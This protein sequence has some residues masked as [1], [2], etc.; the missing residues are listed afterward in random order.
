MTMAARDFVSHRIR[1]L[2]FPEAGEYSVT[3]R[4]FSHG[5]RHKLKSGT[6]QDFDARGQHMKRMTKI[7]IAIACAFG[8]S[9]ALAQTVQR[10]DVTVSGANA[11]QTVAQASTAVPIQTAQTGAAAGGAAGGASAGGF[12]AGIGVPGTVGSTVV[13]VGSAVAATAAASQGGGTSPTSH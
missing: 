6:T 10:G 11:P 2:L 9:A 13:F 7:S 4:L 1:G 3:N 12:V 5:R 8:A